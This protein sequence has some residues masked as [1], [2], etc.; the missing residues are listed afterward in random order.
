MTVFAALMLQMMEADRQAAE[1]LASAELAAKVAD[2]L[3]KYNTERAAAAID[4]ADEQEE[5]EEALVDHFRALVANL[6]KYRPH[7]PNWMLPEASGGDDENNAH[8]SDAD[9]DLQESIGVL[10]YSH[11]RDSGGRNHPDD[12]SSTPPQ[13]GSFTRTRNSRQPNAA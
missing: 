5:A 4:A 7:I 2:A 10:S 11:S 8:N 6:D 1:A 12:G 3:V 9:L 13:S